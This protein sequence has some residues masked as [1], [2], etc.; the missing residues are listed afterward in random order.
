MPDSK[1]FGSITPE[2]FV[3]KYRELGAAK[4]AKELG[5][6]E[7]AVHGRR[8]SLENRMKVEIHGPPREFLYSR[9]HP[10]APE[11]IPLEID[12]GVV[13]VGSDAHY[14]P[15]QVTTAHLAMIHYAKLLKPKVVVMNGDVLDGGRIS[16]HAPIG[17]EK[18]P[19]LI[20]E[21]EV[22]KLRLEEIEKAAPKGCRK[23]WTLG[24]H[25]ARF[26]TRIATIAPE[27]AGVHGV[28]L[29]DHFPKWETAWSVSINHKPKILGGVVITHR[30]KS[31][32]HA[33]HNNALWAGV[34]Y[35]TGHLHSLKVQPISDLHGTRWGVDSG[36]M[37]EPYG[38]QFIDYTEA[39]PVNWRSGIAVL[40]FVDGELLWPELV[41]V[42][43]PE[44]VD[45][46]GERVKV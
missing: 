1:R 31:G 15:G 35:V 11:F 43:G 46:R 10:E 37:A 20:D 6:S 39:N 32:M 36:M 38:S 5:I 26:E 21:I 13:L 18:R 29:K 7:R 16:R 3:E 27:Y 23:I 44:T 9:L 45:F 4:L 25:C 22:C 28:H 17:W 34:S 12:N 30:W 8:K 40:T 2:L 33:P 42:V 19:N 14:W 24:N 41:H